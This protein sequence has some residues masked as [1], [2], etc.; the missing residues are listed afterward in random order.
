MFETLM[1][2]Y[3]A[4]KGPLTVTMLANAVIKEWITDIEKQLILAT[5]I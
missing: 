5:K 1:R 3:A 4:G 2:L